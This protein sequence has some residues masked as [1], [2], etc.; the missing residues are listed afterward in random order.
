MQ[1]RILFLS[2]KRNFEAVFGK[3]RISTSDYLRKN[4]RMSSAKKT[5]SQIWRNLPM[6]KITVSIEP[7]K[8]TK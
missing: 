4:T 2:D 1:A 5:N 7:L 6:E 3:T 8:L